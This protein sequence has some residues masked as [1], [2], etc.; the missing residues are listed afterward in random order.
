MI[1]TSISGRGEGMREIIRPV[2]RREHSEHLTQLENELLEEPTAV[3]HRL[4]TL[5]ILN[6]A[7]VA[8]EVRVI[9]LIIVPVH[10]NLSNVVVVIIVIIV[11]III[12]IWRGEGAVLGRD[13][14]WN[15]HLGTRTTTKDQLH[16][17]IHIPSNI[18]PNKEVETGIVSVFSLCL[19]CLLY[20]TFTFLS[21]DVVRHN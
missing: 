13:V 18:Q 7:V 1:L 9:H 3:P 14:E 11:I 21:L 16:K 15:C 12:G 6:M 2:T 5:I 10:L 17:D 20:Q 4:L 8:E 19:F